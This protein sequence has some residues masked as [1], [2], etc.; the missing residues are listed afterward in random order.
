MLDSSTDSERN[1][2][3]LSQSWGDLLAALSAALHTRLELFFVELHEELER[4]KQSLALFL[5]V[6]GAFGFGFVLLNVF[7]VAFFWQSGWIA[8]IGVLSLIYLAIALF[9]AI[10]LRATLTRPAGL[11][12]ATLAE[13]GKDRDRLGGTHRDA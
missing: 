9:A 7:L 1:G 6:L 3:G 10:R 13:L 5:I 4:G 12:P 8:A 11:F 2:G